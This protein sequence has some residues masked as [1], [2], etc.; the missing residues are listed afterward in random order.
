MFSEIN[1]NVFFQ[2]NIV[3]AGIFLFMTIFMIANRHYESLIARKFRPLVSLLLFIII[4]DNLDNAF[5]LRKIIDIRR[6]I[7]GVLGY[8]IRILILLLLFFA[9]DSVYQSLPLPFQVSQLNQEDL[10]E[11]IDMYNVR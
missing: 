10:A 9:N 1:L 3:P 8:D 2:M 5:Y 7:V 4:I 6:I 11:L